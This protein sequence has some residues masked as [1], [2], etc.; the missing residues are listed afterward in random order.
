MGIVKDTD[1][2]LTGGTLFI[3]QESLCKN[4]NCVLST[5]S[6]LQI[7]IVKDIDYKFIKGTL[8]IL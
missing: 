8:S 1:Y 4:F 3:F 5:Y 2:K 7:G 6:Q